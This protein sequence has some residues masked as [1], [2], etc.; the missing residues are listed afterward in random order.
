[1]VYTSKPTRHTAAFAASLAGMSFRLRKLSAG[2]AP[3]SSAE[4]RVAQPA[5]AIW[6]E[7]R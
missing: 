4:A 2:S 3:L 1:M 5:S 7:T 6:V